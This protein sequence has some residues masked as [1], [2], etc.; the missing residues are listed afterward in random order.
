MVVASCPHCRVNLQI[1]PEFAGQTLQCPNCRGAFIAPINE[2][3]ED[4]GFP[5]LA[6]L[7]CVG[8]A[9]IV[10][11]LILAIVIS[12][13]TAF[14]FVGLAILI[15]LAIWKRKEMMAMF[16]LVRQSQTTKQIVK[17]TASHLRSSAEAA[18]G[19]L[20]QPSSS[21]TRDE[22]ITLEIVDEIDGALVE[23]R[24]AKTAR[25]GP[26]TVSHITQPDGRHDRQPMW[27][28]LGGRPL[29]AKLPRDSV[30]FYGP[31]TELDLGRGV[32]KW[33][34]VYATGAAQRGSFD[35][36]LID[37]TLPVAPLGTPVEERLPYWPNY[38]DCSPAQRAHYLNWLLSGRSDPDTEL[39]YVFIYFY[40]LER[41]VLVDHAEHLPIAQ[42]L[43]RLLLIY[44]NS[45]SFRRYGSALLWLTLYEASHSAAVP[46]ALLAEA[47]KT[48]GRWN[49]ELLG[50]CLAI[51]HNWKQPL[52]ARLAFLVSQNDS[53]SSSSVIV[54]RHRDEFEKLFETKYRERF[55]DGIQLRASKRMKRVNY[56]PA[57]GTLLR[58]L[59]TLDEVSLPGMPD[60]LAISSQFKQ[61]VQSWEESIEELKAY[62]RAT[63]SS[64]GELTAEAYEA[65]PAELQNGD[66][67]ELDA[68]MRAWEEN[69]DNEGWPIVP[70]SALASIK[71]IPSRDRLSKAQCTRLL[72]TA[73]ALGFGV[74]PDARMTGK[75]Y[76]WDERVTMFFLD[77]KGDDNAT[78]YVAAS[79]LL[80]L[81][82]SIAEADGQ[83]DKEELTFITDHL[84]AQFNLSDADSKR[85]ERLQY[86]LL[87]SRS[88]DN[89]I[90]TTLAKTLPRQQRLLVGEFLV[91][92]A[93]V[94]DVITKDETKALRKAYKLLDLDVAELDK[95]IAR[96]LAP[97]V[98]EASTTAQDTELRLDMQAISRI[99]L[100]TREVAVALKNA[101]AEDDEPNSSWNSNATTL[102]LVDP[103]V[104]SSSSTLTA[105]EATID[106][107]LDSRFRPFLAAVL[108]REEWTPSELR[109]LADRC[110]IMLSGAV[111]TINEW[112][113]ERYGDWLIDEGTTYHVRK[114]LIEEAN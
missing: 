27:G 12:P 2:P 85:L 29:D 43:I 59:G 7:A 31:G 57:S 39:G 104:S 24:P 10:I 110:R 88:G 71:G 50:M 114:D 63:R 73:D 14:F 21:A 108:E 113:T 109:E 66:H 74:E 16:Q 112:S 37:G 56:H 82:A 3:E 6:I 20:S 95:L 4:Q 80:R 105:Q 67:P 34:L 25:S 86:L 60:I 72:R 83:V 8:G 75:N 5:L 26:R 46:Q 22:I 100:E 76:R 99:M 30:Y 98:D 23:I 87:H 13:G 58:S 9:H 32:V 101:M 93:A 84:E 103:S 78:N 81:G 65:L 19:F 52:P 44:D 36:S 77:G 45:N 61:I 18:H 49:D 41:R 96:R 107:E 92:V 68:W 90:S 79:V 28:Q 15:E 62:S 11:F 70:V 69:V 55:G 102:A 48:T 17:S 54:R 53:R 106:A 42:E 111:E 94:D 33:P 38:Y 47:I 89:T 40:G 91:G 51:L 97:E 64:G 1:N 35:A